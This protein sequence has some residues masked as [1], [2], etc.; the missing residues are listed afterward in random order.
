MPHFIVYIFKGL[1]LRTFSGCLSKCPYSLLPLWGIRLEDILLHSD[2]V[3]STF[4]V[5]SLPMALLPQFPWPTI[6][7]KALVLP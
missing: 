7:Q 4:S 3:F 1:Q 2:S 5:P 6:L